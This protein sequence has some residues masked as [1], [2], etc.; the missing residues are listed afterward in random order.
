MALEESPHSPLQRKLRAAIRALRPA[1]LLDGQEHA[2]MRVPEM[3]SRHGAGQRQVGR[4]DLVLILRVRLD[5]FG[6]GFGWM[7]GRCHLK[8]DKQSG[9][10]KAGCDGRDC[11][12]AR[13][14]GHVAG[15]VAGMRS[16]SQDFLPDGDDPAPFLDE[17]R[18]GDDTAGAVQ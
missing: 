2:R 6:L 1:C 15:H 11:R 7:H 3:H 16:L 5:Q 14:S 10:A 13:D 18:G 9:P 8:V 4:R 12:T 17:F